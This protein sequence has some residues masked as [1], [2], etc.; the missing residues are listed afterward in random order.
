MGVSRARSLRKRLTQPEAFVWSRL[1]HLRAEGIRVRRQA[2]IGP[3]VVDFAC[4]TARVV[5]EL[6][7]GGHNEPA[8]QQ[9]DRRRDAWLAAN[10]YEVLRIWNRDLYIDHDGAF[11]QMFD[12]L[13]ERHRMVS[14]LDRGEPGEG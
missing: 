4:H 7:G 14:Y 11:D 5:I 9:R 12:L 3:Y 8:Q 1:K 2:Q 6:D 13:R 10:G